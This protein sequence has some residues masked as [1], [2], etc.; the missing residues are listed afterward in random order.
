VF[1]RNA[2]H[3]LY[4][5]ARGVPRLVNVIADRALL[6]AYSESRRNVDGALVD[7]AA[8]EVF[9]VH[10]PGVRRWPWIAALASAGVFALATTNLLFVERAFDLPSGGGDARDAT[11]IAAL[12][13]NGAPEPAGMVRPIGGGTGAPQGAADA[14][15]DADA[16]G[17]LAAKPTGAGPAHKRPRLTLAELI[18]H[19]LFDGS[20]GAAVGDLLE[21][22][23]FT[24]DP[25]RGDPC[26]QA[27]EA[28]LQC[29]DAAR[30]SLGELRNVGWPVVLTLHDTENRARHL[31]VAGLGD[32]HA[33]VLVKGLRF[34]LP[35]AEVSF[36]WYGDHLLVWRPPAHGAILRRGMEHPGVVWL[37]EALAVIAG[38]APPS[39]PSLLFDAELEARVRDYQRK[40]FLGVDG[41]VG[42][43][44]QI[45]LSA[46]LD[47]AGTPHLAEAR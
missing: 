4:R 46:E 5:R 28:G 24:Y 12:P 42:T 41:I 11:G 29:L 36:H 3:R 32:D 13:G 33:V 16:G 38:E 15:A 17:A 23:G 47:R 22:W 44:T 27:A 37:R 21:L 30:G 25:S 1:R 40:R 20:A 31:A 2:V 18:A 9:G 14:L 43:R 10:R 34:E 7:R 8:A 26:A 6:A 35:L 39:A 19:P 45:A